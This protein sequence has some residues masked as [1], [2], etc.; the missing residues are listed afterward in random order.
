MTGTNVEA[1]TEVD[2]PVRH[3]TD[4]NVDYAPTASVWYQWTSPDVASP[5]EMLLS[6]RGSDFDTVLAVYAGGPGLADLTEVV[7]DDDFDEPSG[8]SRLRFQPLQDTVYYFAVDSCCDGTAFGTGSIRL[9]LSEISGQGSIDGFV[10]SDGS[11]GVDGFCVIAVDDSGEQISTTGHTD[12]T[13]EYIVNSVEAGTDRHLKFWNCTGATTYAGEFNGDAQTLAG[14]PDIPISNGQTLH[15]DATLAEGGSISG[16]IGADDAGSSSS[17]ANICVRATMVG[18]PDDGFTVQTTTDTNGDYTLAGLDGGDYQVRFGGDCAA[19]G[20]FATEYYDDAQDPGDAQLVTVTEGSPRT[21][22]DAGLAAAPG[23]I[24]GTVREWETGPGIPN[25]CVR[26]VGPSYTSPS[27]DTDA[28]G[29]YTI[30]NVPVGSDHVV[31]FTDCHTGFNP[32][33]TQWYNRA[34]ALSEAEPITVTSGNTTPSI[35]ASMFRA[36]HLGGHVTDSAGDAREGVC[37]DVY[38]SG[39]SLVRG[40]TTAVDGGWTVPVAP[41]TYQ[42]SFAACGPG[43]V[44]QN[45]WWHS[46]TSQGPAEDV[47]VDQTDSVTNID[48][49]LPDDG[50]ITGR[51]TNSVGNPVPDICVTAFEND[52]TVIAAQDFTDPYGFF[53]LGV[54]AGDYDVQYLDCDDLYRE[55]WYDGE[56]DQASAD[57][58]TVPTESTVR[59]S[60]TLARW[61][62]ISGTI[63]DE[64]DQPVTGICV[65]TFDSNGD[66]LDNGIEN[67]PNGTYTVGGMASGSYRVKFEDCAGSTHGTEFYDNKLDLDSASGVPVNLGSDTPGI[68]V[69]L[70]SEI[71]ENDVLPAING[72]AQVGVTLHADPGQWLHDPAAY[73]YEWYSCDAAGVVCNPVNGVGNSYFVAPS[74]AGKRIRVDVTAENSLGDAT[75][76]APLTDVV[77]SGPPENDD[78]ADRTLLSGSTPIHVVGTNVDATREP[79]EPAHDGFTIGASV[80]YEWTAPTGAGA[81]EMAQLDLSG[82]D[83]TPTISVYDGSPSSFGDLNLVAEDELSSGFTYAVD[84]APVPGTTYY[85]AIDGYWDS[86]TS[87]P[88]EG[89]IDLTLSAASGISGTVTDTSADPIRDICVTA[90]GDSYSLAV[91]T[92]ADGTFFLP[93]P[94]GNYIVDYDDCPGEY[95]R[96]WWEGVNDE[97]DATPV[98]VF[99]ETVTSGIDASSP[100]SSTSARSPGP[101]P[102]R[103]ATSFR[104]SAC[105]PGTAAA[106]TE[107]APGP[108]RTAPTRSAAS[109]TRSTPMTWSTTTFSSSTAA[110]STAPRTT[111]TRSTGTPTRS[112]CGSTSRCSASTRFSST[113]R[114]RTSPS[115]PSPARPASVGC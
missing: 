43:P 22:I 94:P 55:Q 52:S 36:G 67:R 106:V 108:T 18:D 9:R 95:Q 65:S 21:G 110:S 42:V 2:E 30:P 115:P 62:T 85:I 20:D 107:A 70:P 60:A 88:S 69:V 54:V 3:I 68:D 39:G 32:L 100:G 84:W 17:L 96:Q 28:S 89:T 113:T 71:P 64:N 6:T 103:R 91:S 86:T 53:D 15:I 92:A 44:F 58:I 12:V 48:Q 24:S 1:T 8:P 16:T 26:A 72:V 10:T 5:A 101:S 75:A 38:Q 80:W 81:V 97:E 66:Q 99:A 46:R 79:G 109:A 102:T 73:D 29:N 40:T 105:T 7:A 19:N 49:L 35:D 76:S 34:L 114:R 4:D 98:H 61:G 23:A 51:V 41:G 27:Y 77:G 111:T 47:F 50:L 74:D 82:S 83:Y 63:K 33:T 59:A 14:A 57:T 37:V 104:T 11:T 31:R 25:I 90:N 13:G 112:A 78:I 87:Q 93:V 45:L 56:L